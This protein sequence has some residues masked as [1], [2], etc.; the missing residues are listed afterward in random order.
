MFSSQRCVLHVANRPSA[1][2]ARSVSNSS[3]RSIPLA[4]FNRR[5]PAIEAAAPSNRIKAPRSKAAFKA[6]MTVCE[7]NRAQS[8]GIAI[9]L[10]DN[11]ASG[12]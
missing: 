5:S 1:R 2:L 10:N 4:A 8:L 6:L 3:R 11:H 9:R 12:A 7:I